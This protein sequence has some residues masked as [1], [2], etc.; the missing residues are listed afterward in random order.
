MVARGGHEKSIGKHIKQYENIYTWLY[1]VVLYVSY[2]FP[3]YFTI[4]CIPKWF[5]ESQPVAA[6]GDLNPRASEIYQEHEFNPAHLRLRRPEK[7]KSFWG[8]YKEH[9]RKSEA[10]N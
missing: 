9:K 2:V 1:A 5:L 7:G 8:P 6:S 3:T 10:I 4:S